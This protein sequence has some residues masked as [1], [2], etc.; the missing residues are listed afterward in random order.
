MACLA[1]DR[2]SLRL[3]LELAARESGAPAAR[4]AEGCELPAPAS[5]K[6]GLPIVGA[7]GLGADELPRV[8]CAV[9]MDFH[10]RRD[11]EFWP[12]VRYAVLW[13]GPNDPQELVLGLERLLRDELPGFAFRCAG[14]GAL[15]LQVGR[16]SGERV[17]TTRYAV[18]VGLDLAGVLDEAAGAGH[19]P[20]ETLSLFRFQTGRGEL[21]AF[22]RGLA[23]ELAEIG[24][25]GRAT[26]PGEG[27]AA[28]R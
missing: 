7:K 13:L 14:L 1:S 27:T 2:G 8:L 20:G 25:L 6:I 24:G 18:E 22:A 11:G 15:G 10:D 5:A 12:F 28:R 21:V 16:L 17:G 4:G 23:D 9:S 3:S 19:P 26:P